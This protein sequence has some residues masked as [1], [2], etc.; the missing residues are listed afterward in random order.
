VGF[1]KLDEGIVTST[2]WFEEDDVLRVWIYLL[3]C[4]DSEG[5]VFVTVPA[6]AAHNKMSVDRAREIL[7]KF[8]SPDP[9]SRNQNHEGR[10]IAITRESD[11]VIEVL[12]YQNYRLKDHT[13][14]ERQ[15]RYRERHKRDA[16]D[17]SQPSRVPQGRSQKSE[18]RRQRKESTKDSPATG[19]RR[20]PEIVYPDD[21]TAFWKAYPRK[22]DKGEAF[23]AWQKIR[24]PRPT[25]E[26]VL[27]SITSLKTSRQWTEENGRFIPHPA[28]WLNR[29]GWESEV[30]SDDFPRSQSGLALPPLKGV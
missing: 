9:D 2:I 26:A 10:R 27:A 30:S 1:T 12:N 25:L 13:H 16:R 4:A 14:A 15:R 5:L 24:P 19:A 23:K 29:R 11:F 3:A 17:A 6:I 20:A 7:E 18:V 28:T 21:F 22:I 8:A